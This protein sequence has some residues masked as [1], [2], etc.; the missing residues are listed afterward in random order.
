MAE[1]KSYTRQLSHE[2]LA[3][4]RNLIQ[5]KTECVLVK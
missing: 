3:L 1:L 5:K 2:F 4:K